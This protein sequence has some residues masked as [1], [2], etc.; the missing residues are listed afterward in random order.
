MDDGVYSEVIR[1]RYEVL[2][3]YTVKSWRMGGVRVKG[4]TNISG[5]KKV[6]DAKA[7][8]VEHHVVNTP[9]LFHT[10]PAK[11]CGHFPKLEDSG[12]G[13]APMSDEDPVHVPVVPDAA[14]DG[15]FP[16]HS[17]AFRLNPG[18]VG[19]LQV[20]QHSALLAEVAVQHV[21]YHLRRPLV[22]LHHCLSLPF[23]STPIP[24]PLHNPISHAILLL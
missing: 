16:V 20:H 9:N 24:I 18:Q 11:L 1:K 7:S 12:Y 10:G 23:L 3:T 4:I 15:G 13:P 14:S 22:P 17:V 8:H 21:P 5:R 6:V 19:V 2:G